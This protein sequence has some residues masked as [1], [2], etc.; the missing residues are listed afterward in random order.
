MSFYTNTNIICFCL[1]C[2]LSNTWEVLIWFG[3]FFNMQ[4]LLFQMISYFFNNIYSLYHTIGRIN[5]I[6]TSLKI[7]FY[8]FL[9][10]YDSPWQSWDFHKLYFVVNTNMLFLFCVQPLIYKFINLECHACP[11]FHM[12]YM[13][14]CFDVLYFQWHS[15]GVLQPPLV[16]RSVKSGDTHPSLLVACIWHT[17][18]VG[19]N[20]QSPTAINTFLS[21]L[22]ISHLPPCM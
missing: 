10:D 9:V 2:K 13:L 14:D 15:C 5:Y 17:Y 6:L 19:Y 12:K 22:V 1:S 18:K 11:C 8:L 16:R 4:Y 3:T 20:H 21:P 7:D